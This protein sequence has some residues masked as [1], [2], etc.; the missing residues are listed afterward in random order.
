MTSQSQALYLVIVHLQLMQNHL[1]CAG[2]EE[3]GRRILG[4]ACK[5]CKSGEKARGNYK[6]SYQY[7]H[8]IRCIM[9]PYYGPCDDD[10]LRYSSL[11][12]EK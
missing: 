9:D 5:L 10:P 11:D 2:I 3:I 8:S 7:L 6:C 12:L 4:W 1:L